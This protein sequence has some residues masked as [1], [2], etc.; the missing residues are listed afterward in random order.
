M[1]RQV[2]DTFS[3]FSHSQSNS[4]RIAA[5]F[6]TNA[7]FEVSK[8]MQDKSGRILI[9]DVKVSDSDFLLSNL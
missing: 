1:E 5:D 8:K 6:I 4:C 7:S 9:L 2:S 3:L